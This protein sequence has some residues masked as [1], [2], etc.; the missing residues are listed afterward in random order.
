MKIKHGIILLLLGFI[1]KGI[2][3]LFRIQHWEGGGDLL[4]IS[5]FFLVAGIII[6]LFKIIQTYQERRKIDS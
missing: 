5:T 1:L 3:F 2:G 6:F 4:L